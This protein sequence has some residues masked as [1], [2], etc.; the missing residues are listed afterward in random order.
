MN[1]K[2]RN[3]S[4]EMLRIISMIL[5]V[6]HHYAV[7][8]FETVEM[9]YS[10]NRYIIGVLSLGG[11]VGVSCYI[12][13]SG[14]FMI[15]SKF[16]LYKLVK[17]LGEVWFYSVGIGILFAFVLTPVDAL[18]WKIFIKMCFPI[19]YSGHWF[20]TDYILLMLVSPLL[21]IVISNIDKKNYESI[22][23]MATLFWS[24]IHS[25]TLAEYGYTVIGWFVILYL[26]A[27]YIRKYV[28]I[29]N[30]NAKKHFCVA[31]ISYAVIILS[32]IMMIF[33]GNYLS[34]DKFITY[35]S[36][37][38]QLSSPFVLLTSSEL[39]ITFAKVKP[40]QNKM[41]NIAASAT[42]GIYLI[43]D[44]GIFAPYLWNILLKTPEMYES[45]WLII[46][47]IVSILSIYLSCTLIDLLRQATVEKIFL[48]VLD[49][50]LD[51]IKDKVLRIYEKVAVRITGLVN[52]YYK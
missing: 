42:L 6:S 28:D 30:N 51:K 9:G 44:D 45:K 26:Y 33:L 4:L 10:F 39:L 17:L 43:H 25:F 22:L 52:W 12:L 24:I 34:I 48:R 3:S 19:G 1:G 7:H 16:R 11:Q 49:K 46:H 35:S 41:I 18:S 20:M 31:V 15:N 29:E 27:G 40:W 38:S 36:Y 13:I 37:F 23:I 2:I 8:G 50:Y 47:A 32:S 5:I 14:Y 21:N